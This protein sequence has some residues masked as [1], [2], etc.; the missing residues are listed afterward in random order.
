MMSSLQQPE[1]FMERLTSPR[2]VLLTAF[3]GMA[4]VLTG[5]VLGIVLYQGGFDFVQ[6]TISYLGSP[7]HNP[8]FYWIF[9]IGVTTFYD[10]DKKYLRY[11]E[12]L[13][14]LYLIS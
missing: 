11:I 8:E 5:I 2:I 14:S 3:I 6:E 1:S 7:K 12:A 10:K 13:I 9:N 4:I